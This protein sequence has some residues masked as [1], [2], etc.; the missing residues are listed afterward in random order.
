MGLLWLGEVPSLLGI[1]GGVMA[2]AGVALV[3][4]TRR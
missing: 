4:L 2:L 3:N 1:A